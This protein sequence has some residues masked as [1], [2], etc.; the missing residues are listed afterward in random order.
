MPRINFKKALAQLPEY[1][2]PDRV[3]NRIEMAL[4]FPSQSG[5]TKASALAYLEALR[6]GDFAEIP[7]MPGFLYRTPLGRMELREFTASARALSRLLHS[8]EVRGILAD[9]DRACLRYSLRFRDGRPDFQA[10]DWL[11]FTGGKLLEVNAYFDASR[12][13]NQISA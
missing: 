2:P 3:W 4:G 6:S 1:D 11:S 9:G 5:G 13:L 10:V 7:F 12:L 8:L